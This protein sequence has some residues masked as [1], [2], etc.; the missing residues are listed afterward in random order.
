M[1]IAAKNL[2]RDK[3]RLAL[4]VTGVA[5]AIMLILILNGF[6]A[7]IN[8]QVSA[9]LDHAPGSVAVLQAGS[10]GASS[11]IPSTTADVVRRVDGVA[12]VVPVTSQWA[13]IDLSGSKQLLYVLGYDPA[14]GGGP[15]MMRS[16]RA[17]AADNE[18][19]FDAVLAARRGVHINDRLSLMGRTLT[20]VGLSDGTTSWMTSY[21]FV[22]NTAAEKIFGAPGMV[23]YLLVTP[24]GGVTDAQLK[25]RLQGIPGTEVQLKSEMIDTSRRLNAGVFNIPLQ[26]MA[27]IAALVGTLVVGLVVYSSTIERQ[28]EYGVLKA[29]GARNRVLYQVV[30][31]QALVAAVAGAVVGVALAALAAQGIMAVRPQ[32]LIAIQPASMGSAMAIA[33]GMAA[34]AA[35]LP[36]RLLARLAPADV[37]RR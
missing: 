12:R 33:L 11:V 1:G 4:S 19:V 34:V 6:I 20:V 18:M 7:G 25:S 3:T 10:G 9:Y 30:G 21:V 13:I 22:R 28:R 29:I 17:P 36:A 32:F 8:L 27:A 24:R 23:S 5:L 2:L 16:G 15:W 37:F 14:T 31:T 26:L 35:L